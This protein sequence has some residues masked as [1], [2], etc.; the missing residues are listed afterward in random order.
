MLPFK[1]WLRA[2][3]I[4]VLPHCC[5]A[6]KHSWRLTLGAFCPG[7]TKN[8]HELKQR[9]GTDTG[10]CWCSC[11]DTHIGEH[12]E[13]FHY[14]HPCVS[15]HKQP[16]LWKSDHTAEASASL[17][18]RSVRISPGW[19][20]NFILQG[21]ILAWAS[22][23]FLL[24]DHKLRKGKEFVWRFACQYS[25]HTRHGWLHFF[26]SDVAAQRRVLGK[27]IWWVG[28]STKG[29]TLMMKLRTVSKSNINTLAAITCY[30]GLYLLHV[31]YHLLCELHCSSLYP[32]PTKS[33]PDLH[34]PLL[35]MYD[36]DCITCACVCVCECMF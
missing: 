28:G 32:T 5:S 16:I 3:H 23:K 11:A 12:T 21:L 25:L 19:N 1:F 20:G 18:L 4:E 15:A 9:L 29:T 35:S 26:F 10:M 31:L 17:F 30:G 8:L 7:C 13:V 24:N 22:G 36:H 14:L 27:Q 33:L 6:I 2:L 34:L